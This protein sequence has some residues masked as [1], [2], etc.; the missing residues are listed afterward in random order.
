VIITSEHARRNLHRAR[1]GGERKFYN[2]EFEQVKGIKD[3][4]MPDAEC[5][6][7]QMTRH[8]DWAP[9]DSTL[10]VV[11]LY[12]RLVAGTKVIYLLGRSIEDLNSVRI[13]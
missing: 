1:D 2:L 12:R 6:M 7:P 5:P 13:M 3:M 4:R 11:Q 9:T 10:L 8:H